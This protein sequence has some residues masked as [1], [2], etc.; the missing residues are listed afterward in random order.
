MRQLYIAGVVIG[1]SVVATA[2]AQVSV[3][4]QQSTDKTATGLQVN[5]ATMD[6]SVAPVTVETRETKVDDTTTCSESVTRARLGDGSYFDLRSTTATTRQADAN[7]TQ[8]VIETVEN[9]RQGGQ[10]TARRVTTETTKTATGE[11]SDT[12]TYR[13]DS[14]GKLVLEGQVQSTTTRNPDGSLNTVS[15]ELRTD[16]GG[17]LQPQRRIEQTTT[18]SDLGGKQ[19]VT[20]IMTPNHVNSGY[21]VT[22]RETATVRTD[23]NSTSTEVLIQSPNGTSWQDV[24]KI[25]T[26]ESRDPNGS[27]QRET[28]EE[29]QSQYSP[30]G[31]G[32]EPLVPQR[33]I[34]ES[35][36]HN[37]DGT[38]L[39]ERNVYRRDINGDWKPLTFSTE[40]P[41]KAAY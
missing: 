26:T 28:V 9:D 5:V 16:V 11:Q 19:V 30:K 17:A 25:L 1:I 7:T 18:E 10:H 21:S 31:Q 22:S 24:G 6:R 14:S 34:V 41:G 36:V 23:G 32:V 39:M 20:R 27:V 3:T 29:G 12:S 8:T 35:E 40:T 15:V 4:G 33:K 2:P 13:R 38:I 37:P